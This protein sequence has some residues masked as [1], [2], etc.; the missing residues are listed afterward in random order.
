MECH[1]EHVTSGGLLGRRWAWG[2]RDTRTHNTHIREALPLLARLLLSPP[3]SPG[4]LDLL[5]PYVVLGG[6]RDEPD[7]FQN[8][9]YVVDTSLLDAER[10]GSF[11]EVE[12][13][14]GGR[15]KEV[16][17]P[18]R[19]RAKRRFGSPLARDGVLCEAVR[20]KFTPAYLAVSLSPLT[21][22]HRGTG[23]CYPSP[24]SPSR[25]GSVHFK[26][27]FDL[28]GMRISGRG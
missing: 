21:Y 27:A 19:Q 3:P 26:L 23:G 1:Y 17:E 2:T 28:E 4:P 24:C 5:P 12:D 22:L 20:G 9:G 25:T 6:L 8:V 14:V 18:L 15:V 13:T 11:V 10:L 7:T 16:A